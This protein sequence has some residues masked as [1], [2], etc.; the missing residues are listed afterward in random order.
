VNKNKILIVIFFVISVLAN[1]QGSLPRKF[2]K[3]AT[4]INPQRLNEVNLTKG[5]SLNKDSKCL[6]YVCSE[7]A[8]VSFC[9][10]KSDEN[11]V[12][13]QELGNIEKTELIIINKFTYNEEFYILLNKSNCKVVTLEGFPLRIEN[14]DLYIVYNNP[15]TDKNR[16]IQ[17][18][19]MEN[20]NILL[21]DEIIFPDEIRLKKILRL[22]QN[23]IFILDES[24]QIWKAIVKT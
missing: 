18:L 17:I 23:E 19:K 3:I 5:F 24:N 21:Q 12:E 10:D 6:N 22:E 9:N 14:T 1:A 2:F 20:G 8:K 16:K 11:Y 7:N 13:F 4:V 15:S